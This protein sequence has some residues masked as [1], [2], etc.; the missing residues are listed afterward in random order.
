MGELGRPLL[1]WQ[2]ID[3]RTFP[4]VWNGGAVTTQSFPIADDLFEVPMEE[5]E[6]YRIVVDTIADFGPDDT[7]VLDQGSRMD[8]QLIGWN[9]WQDRVDFDIAATIDKSL[10]VAD[11]IS[12][13]VNVFRLVVR[14]DQAT[15]EV[16]FQHLDDYLRDIDSGIDWRDRLSHNEPPTKVAADLPSRYIFRW[17]DDT[18]DKQLRQYEEFWGRPL[19]EGVY[20]M[21]GIGEEKEVTVKFAPTNNLGRFD[22]FDIPVINKDDEGGGTTVVNGGGA[23]TNYG[24]DFVKTKPRMLVFAGPTPG[25]WR[26][27]GIPQTTYPRAYFQG[28]GVPDQS[29]DFGSD[30]RKGTLDTFW[31]ESLERSKLPTLRGEFRVYDDEFMGFDFARP[32]LVNDGHGDV[33]MYVQSVKG[34]K[35]GDDDLVECE[36]IPV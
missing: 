7:V 1:P 18:S 29:L 19:G 20:E 25:E 16:I 9:G 26:F 24:V 15:N 30:W 14:T 27:D 5:N 31:R 12:T 21:G 8:G 33:W 22:D 35:F 17:S 13:L 36:L 23:G 32:R 10:S 28:T 4:L 3:T 11:I 34:K 2:T 6:T